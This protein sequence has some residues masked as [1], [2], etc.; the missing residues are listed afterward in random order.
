MALFSRIKRWQNVAQF[1][2]SRLTDYTNLA[3]VEF[4]LIRKHFLRDVVLYSLLGLSLMFGMAFVCVAVIVSAA[5]TPYLIDTAWA[6]AAFWGVVSIGSF[7]ATRSRN[8]S[9]TF[10]V[11]SEELQRDIQTIKESLQ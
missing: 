4:D 9:G 10:S 8:D 1:S 5:R 6:V 11:L 2:A 7:V 3:A